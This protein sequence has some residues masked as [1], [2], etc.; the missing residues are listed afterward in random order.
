MPLSPRAAFVDAAGDGWIELSLSGAPLVGFH[1]DIF[2]CDGRNSSCAPVAVFGGSGGDAEAAGWF[3]AAGHAFAGVHGFCL[4]RGCGAV[5]PTT[6]L[7]TRLSVAFPRS[8][9]SASVVCV[10]D[11]VVHASA[12]STPSP[13]ACTPLLAAPPTAAAPSSAGRGVAFVKTYKTGSSTLGSLLHRHAD[14]HALDVAMNAKAVPHRLSLEAHL[15]K[16][17]KRARPTDCL[18]E[19]HTLKACGAQ[20]VADQRGG[21][22]GSGG[23]RPPPL[24][25]APKPFGLLADHSRWQPLDEVKSRGLMAPRLP[26]A[27]DAYVGAMGGATTTPRDLAAPAGAARLV[28]CIDA[29]VKE[30]PKGTTWRAPAAY[31]DTVAG[32]LLLTS[33]RWPPFCSCF[34]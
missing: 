19:F 1:A 27:C 32:G 22:V 21:G 12:S 16:R 29:L 20:W 5:T 10:M 30:N 18:F 14:T 8:P 3:I 4:G 2:A 33:A 13:R 31:R 28:A 34:N 15:E 25:L 9:S 6:G 11:A 17:E 7:L 24:P 23:P 26:P